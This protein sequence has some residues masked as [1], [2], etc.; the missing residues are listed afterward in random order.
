MFH[1]RGTLFRYPGNNVLT[2]SSTRLASVSYGVRLMLGRSHGAIFRLVA[3]RAY[4][5]H[6]DAAHIPP[7]TYQEQSA[8]ALSDG[9]MGYQTC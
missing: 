7:Y 3:G 2:V 4:G 6:A 8:S 5:W 9:T 1:A